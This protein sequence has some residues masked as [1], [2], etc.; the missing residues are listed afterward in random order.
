[1]NLEL[2]IKMLIELSKDEIR[3]IFKNQKKI[4][5]SAS[6]KKISGFL[7]I[8]LRQNYYS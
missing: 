1:M 8:I 2:N 4:N 5:Q 6:L 3:N 7:N